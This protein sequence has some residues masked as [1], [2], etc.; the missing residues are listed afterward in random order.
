MI[1]EECK[2]IHPYIRSI[3]FLTIELL[4]ARVLLRK[5]KGIHPLV[6]KPYLGYFPW[7]IRGFIPPRR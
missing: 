4:F 3:T 6:L 5:Y 7:G 2:C 1:G